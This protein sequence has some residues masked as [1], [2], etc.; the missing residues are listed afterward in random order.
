MA[1]A[2][3]GVSRAGVVGAALAVVDANGW[4]VLSLP[5]VADALGV[6]VPS[7]YKHVEG[8][9]GLRRAVAA[10][11]TAQLAESMTLATMGRSG[12]EAVTALAHVYRAF[13]TAHP[14]RYAATV[15]APAPDD[16]AHVAAAERALAAVLAAVRGYGLDD[17]LA[18]HA[19]R[20][21]RAALHGFVALE[22]AGGFGMPADIDRSFALM[23]ADYDATLRGRTAARP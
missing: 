15:A 4:E 23:V 13:A 19:I 18:V 10:E 11:C 17:E 12:A 16:A 8:L 2:K 22:A 14:G 1:V 21:L 7:L 6:R 3:A 5:P 9:P 20:A